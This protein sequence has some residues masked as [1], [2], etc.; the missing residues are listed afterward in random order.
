MVIKFSLY[1]FLIFLLGFE[2]ENK[3]NNL[4]IDDTSIL[5]EWFMKETYIS[6][7]GSTEWQDIN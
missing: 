2:S 6:Q 5:G 3:T 4:P 7:G 1:I